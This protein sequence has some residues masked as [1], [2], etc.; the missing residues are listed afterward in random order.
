MQC[1]TAPQWQQSQKDLVQ[2]QAE[3]TA[4]SQSAVS[5]ISRSIRA[6]AEKEWPNDYEMQK[7]EINKQTEAYN[8]VVTTSSATGVPQEVFDQ[9]KTKAASE[10]PDDYEMQKYEIEKQVK[11]YTELH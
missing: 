8:W 4:Q 11:A 5:D 9:I 6:K 3:L 2:Q 10:W 1:Q 7:Y